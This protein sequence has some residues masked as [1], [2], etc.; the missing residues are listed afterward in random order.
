LVKQSLIEDGKAAAEIAFFW[1]QPTDKILAQIRRIH[2]LEIFD[3]SIEKGQGVLL[4]APH[5]GAWELLCHYLSTRMSCAI[6][7]RQPRHLGFEPI[8]TQARA[9]L[10]AELIRADASGV[11]Q[12]FRAAKENK[13]IGI[14]PDQQ[15]K[16]GTGEFAPFFGQSALTMVLYSRLAARTPASL[17]AFGRWRR[18]RST[19]FS[20]RRFGPVE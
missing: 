10:G 11:R 6:L 9:R 15:P 2:G 16:K 17:R 20:A 14:L 12:L 19:L 8:I 18:F 4:A 3:R 1:R 5:L 13:L 7:Y